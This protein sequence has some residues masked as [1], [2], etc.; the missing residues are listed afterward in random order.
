[1]PWSQMH[2]LYHVPDRTR[3]LSEIHRVLRPGG[4]L[5]ATTMGRGH[6]REL[7]EL[8]E[9]I[10]PDAYSNGTSVEEFGLENGT[11]QLAEWFPE[12][13]LHQSL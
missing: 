9:K 7:R 2:M 6:L 11:D 12:I 8:V 1:M 10:V 4:R 3:A 13:A 5:L